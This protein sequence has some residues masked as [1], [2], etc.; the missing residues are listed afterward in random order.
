MQ[1]VWQIDKSATASDWL[2]VWLAT[3][4]KLFVPRTESGASKGNEL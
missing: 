1:E 2:D 4:K 3:K